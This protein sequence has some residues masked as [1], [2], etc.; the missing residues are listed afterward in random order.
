MAQNIQLLIIDP[1]NDFCDLPADWRANNP[2]TGEPMVP[3]LPVVGAHADMLRVAEFI[4]AAGDSLSAITLT[5]D[6]HHRFHIAHPTFW[7]TVPGGAVQPFTPITAAQVR[8]GEYVPRDPTGL[9]RALAYLDELER[10]GRYTLMVWPV[11]CEIGSWGHGVHPAVKAAYNVWEDRRL[12]LVQKITKGSNPWT[13]HYSALQA[14]VPDPSDPHTQL[15]TALINALDEA[16]TLVIAGEA[17]S[18]CVRASTEHLVANLPSRR[19]SKVVLLT[20]CMS[21]VGSFEA[22]HRDFLG[23]MQAQGARLTTSAQFLTS[24]MTRA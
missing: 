5:L 4:R 15:N 24:I 9:P 10:Q 20:D 7:Q 6:S 14:E 12:T 3:A 18:H 19:P 2:L 11:H 21:P 22:Q 13:E 8:A 23:G 17:S 16:D 1:Q